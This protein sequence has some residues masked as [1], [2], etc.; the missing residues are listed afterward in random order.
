M[1]KGEFTFE[2]NNVPRIARMIFADYI[3]GINTFDY[4]DIYEEVTF[5]DLKEVFEKLLNKDNMAISI[6]EGKDE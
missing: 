3:K 2:F 6:I 4:F 1:L 5:D